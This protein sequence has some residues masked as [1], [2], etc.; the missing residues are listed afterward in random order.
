MRWI[1]PNINDKLNDCNNKSESIVV[2]FLAKL[3]S[4]SSITNNI[5]QEIV[6][7]FREL[8]KSLTDF[9][10]DKLKANIPAEFHKTIESCIEIDCL[11]K[12]DSNYKRINYLK[13]ISYFISPENF[14]MGEINNDKK[15]GNVTLWKKKCTG[16]VVPMR[17]VLKKFLELP[18]VYIMR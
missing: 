5:V 1:R 6:N 15:I 10:L 18:N 8:L 4:R 12:F 3:F 17:T 16:V 7:D 14:I 13:K 9:Y 11:D 2:N